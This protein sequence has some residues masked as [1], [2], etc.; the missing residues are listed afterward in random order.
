MANWYIKRDGYQDGPIGSAEL[1]ARA[2]SGQIKRT[3]MVRRE[4]LHDFLAAGSIKGLFPPPT[5]ETMPPA[6]Q[7]PLPNRATPQQIRPLRVHPS[8]PIEPTAARKVSIVNIFAGFILIAILAVCIALGWQAIQLPASNLAAPSTRQEEDVAEQL[9]QLN[10]R[11]EEWKSKRSK[12]SGLVSNL[13]QDKKNLVRD[14]HLLGASPTDQK[15]SN[16]KA[17]VLLAE[18][19]D[20]LK[21]SVVFD[22]KHKE[23]DLAIFKSESRVRTFERRIAAK[24]VAGSD[25]ELTALIRSMAELDQELD[26]ESKD[27]IP[28]ELDDMVKN[29]LGSNANVITTGS[30]TNEVSVAT[31]PNLR[32]DIQKAIQGKW[33]C[34]SEFGISSSSVKDSDKRLEVIGSNFNMYRKASG[35]QFSNIGQFSLEIPNHFNWVGRTAE[36]KPLKWTGIYLYDGKTFSLCYRA[37]ETGLEAVR[38]DWGDRGNSGVV[39]VD[40]IRDDSSVSTSGISTTTSASASTGYQPST[41][42][43]EKESRNTFQSPRENSP[44]KPL[45]DN[46]GLPT[47]VFYLSGDLQRGNI[48]SNMNFIRFGARKVDGKIG[49]AIY[50]DGVQH[51]E[52]EAALPQRSSPRSLAMWIRNNRGPVNQNIHIINQGPTEKAQSFGIMEAAGRWRFFDLDGGLDTG[53]KIDENWHHHAI[54]YDGGKLT[55]YLDGTI[56]ALTE[57]QLNTS[58]GPLKIGGLGSPS[59][60]FVGLVDEVYFFDVPLSKNQVN[61]LM[62]LE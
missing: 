34:I 4:D 43:T 48:P 55:Y 61:I 46:S 59:N 50:F 23:Y 12:L 21:Q 7:P 32:L 30:D 52:V 62:R 33:K 24:E 2:S 22:K 42:K 25:E 36:G 44:T 57:R 16:P 35:Q 60:N 6:D 51:V 26:S 58:K 1:K 28:I 19:R 47:P 53:V 27:E 14:L 41:S 39:A 8:E 9:E 49:N 17:S 31:N 15:S 40:F 38:P 5:G 18:L 3:D 11:I 54:T 37:S 29:A 20:V 10:T 13:D 45:R 56:V